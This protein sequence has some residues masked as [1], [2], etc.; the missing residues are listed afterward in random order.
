MKTLRAQERRACNVFDDSIFGISVRFDR[1]NMQASN[2][3]KNI[4][5]MN[6][7]FL[8]QFDAD[9]IRRQIK[10]VIESNSF[11]RSER[12]KR[13]LNFA[14]K[15][16]LEG[17]EETLK[18]YSIAVEV[19]DKPESFDPRLDPIVRVE[20]GRL[21]SKLREYYETEGREDPILVAFPKRSYVPVFEARQ[22]QPAY[23][24]ISLDSSSEQHPDI[25][26]ARHEQA[27]APAAGELTS[28]AVLPFAD[29]SPQKNQ[30]YFCNGI[31]EEIVNALSRVEGLQVVSR[32]S[33]MQFK[34][35]VRDIRQIGLQLNVGAVLEGS[36]RRA[37]RRVRITAQLTNVADGYY[38]WSDVYDRV[39]DDI[40]KVQEQIAQSIVKALKIRLIDAPVS[41]FV[42]YTTQNTK[43]YQQYLQGRH[44]WRKRDQ[45]GLRKA[46]RYF[47][48]AIT[49][50]PSY[51]PAYA[52]LAES[53]T[54]LVWLG[55]LSPQVGWPKVE[56]TAQMAL[57]IDNGSSRALAS[58]GSMRALYDWDWQSAENEFK[59]AIESDLRNPT[60][61]QWYSIFCLAPQGRIEEALLYIAQAEQ[62]EPA[63]P[64]IRSHHGWLLY[65]QREYDAAGEQLQRSLSLDPLLYLTHWYL[66]LVFEQQGNL[67]L[68]YE[69][70]RRA[71]ELSGS[72]P[73]T[74]GAL[75]RCHALMG[76]R[77]GALQTLN[78][79]QK[80]AGRRYVSPVELGVIYTAL[81]ETQSALEHLDQASEIRCP[82]LAHLRIDPAFDTLRPDP[83]FSRLL[84]KMALDQ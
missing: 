20:A 23:S 33:T 63:S 14:V 72:V 60:A 74:L 82:R 7:G 41:G 31:T 51:A 34:E 47:E 13:F 27:H 17:K 69:S 79:L 70:F 84:K 11:V 18:E 50:D 75:G 45:R 81:G 61:C 65:W 64:L 25:G 53:Y 8:G 52:G 1:R 28:L 44:Y 54:A 73:L 19:F 43:A 12:M 68:A 32:T 22:P 3:V 56:Q 71:Q 36:V 37:G 10:K 46:I 40:F 57:E 26:V 67:Q 42:R 59:R 29:L 49:H 9:A 16:T 35:E 5:A 38:L 78:N 30:D 77:R 4:Q 15:L 21:R 55:T 2:G 6:T 76:G 39:I 83:A 24:P 48:R 66:G 58:L 62:L 80:Q